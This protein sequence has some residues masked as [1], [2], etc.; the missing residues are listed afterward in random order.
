MAIAR[1]ALCSV[2]EWGT[3]YMQ[4]NLEWLEKLD[5]PPLEFRGHFE[6]QMCQKLDYRRLNG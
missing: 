5:L 2:A 6:A 4:Q 3:L 1:Q